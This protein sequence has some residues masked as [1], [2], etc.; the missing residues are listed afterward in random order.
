MGKLKE[1][2]I[3]FMNSREVFTEEDVR[4]AIENIYKERGLKLYDNSLAPGIMKGHW[5]TE[6]KVTI[7]KTECPNLPNNSLRICLSGYGIGNQSMFYSIDSI[8][9]NGLT[10]EDEVEVKIWQ[11]MND[12]IVGKTYR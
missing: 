1:H 12:G 4:A 5:R 8:T 2:I 7:Y 11:D 10:R 6:N 9:P 3:S